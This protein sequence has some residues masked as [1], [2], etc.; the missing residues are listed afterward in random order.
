MNVKKFFE[1]AAS[2]GISECQIM[3]SNSKSTRI[4]LF[5]HEIDTYKIS[6]SRSITAIG[7]YNGKLGSGS[8]ELIGNEAFEFLVEQIVLTATYSEKPCEVGLFK[9]AEKYKKSRPMN[10]DLALTPISKKLQDLRDLENMVLAY[11]SRIVEADGVSYTESES[12]G[13]IFNSSGVHLKSESNYYYFVA[14][15]V[16]KEGDE[17]KTF[18]D[19]YFD[20]DY[21]KFNKEELA[22]K[23]CDKALRKFGGKPCATKKYPTVLERDIMAELLLSFLDNTIAEKV[24]KK[25]SSLE[26]K[27]GTKIASSKLTVEEKPL[28]KTMFFAPYDDELVP[29]RNKYLIKDGVL[30]TY[31]YNRETAAKD[32]VETTGNGT[33]SGT[34]FGTGIGP[35]YVKPGK[36]SFEEMIAPIKEG[37]YITEIAGLGTG[38]NVTSGDFSCQA[39]GFM[40]V[41]GKLGAPLNLITISGNLFKLLQD[42][43]EFAN[44]AQLAPNGSPISIADCYIKSLNIGGE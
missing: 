39:E 28:A 5:R 22:R 4:K 9:G 35:L 16:A 10:K 36:K 13:E 7:V 21:S 26:G 19:I 37:V 44:N 34:K 14:G 41:D 11:D 33:W 43:K 38:M 30:Q 2:K 31:L 32:G 42:I 23:V 20:E 8:T 27:I 6:E 12:H 1:L 17:T 40:I 24:Q 18:Y 29:S 3:I 25:T 15:A